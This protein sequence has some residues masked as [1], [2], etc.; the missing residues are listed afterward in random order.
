MSSVFLVIFEQISQGANIQFIHI[1]Q[2][3]AEF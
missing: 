3:K 1:F 2:L